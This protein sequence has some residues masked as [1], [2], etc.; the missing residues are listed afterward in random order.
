MHFIGWFLGKCL[1]IFHS[2]AG[3]WGRAP[4]LLVEVAWVIL[5]L[6]GLYFAVYRLLWL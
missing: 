6:Y 3:K 5:G 2:E 4:A 1:S